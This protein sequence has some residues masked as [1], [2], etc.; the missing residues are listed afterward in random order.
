MRIVSEKEKVSIDYST[1]IQQSAALANAM[2]VGDIIYRYMVQGISVLFFSCTATV[3]TLIYSA[4]VFLYV[5][6]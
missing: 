5:C 6:Y 2:T 4:Y 1:K 3:C